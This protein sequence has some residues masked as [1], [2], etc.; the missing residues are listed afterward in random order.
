MW[1]RPPGEHRDFLDCVR[2][3]KATTY[4]P[5]MGHRLSTVMHI[6]NIAIELTRKLRWDPA[7]E[8][9]ND[10]AADALKTRA[11]RGNWI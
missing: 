7:A 8:T 2:S 6:G 10:A 4:T 3:R 1:K 11:A 9:F 5:E